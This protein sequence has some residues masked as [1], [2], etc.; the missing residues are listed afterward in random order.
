MINVVTEY[1]HGVQEP[2][3]QKQHQKSI[4]SMQKSS[5]R[6]STIDFIHK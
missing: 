5:I 2:I 3:T 6:S 1:T 4:E